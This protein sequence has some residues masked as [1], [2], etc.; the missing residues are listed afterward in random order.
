MKLQWRGQLYKDALWKSATATTITAFKK[1]MEDLKKINKD[2]YEWLNKIPAEHWSRSHFS[3]KLMVQ[4]YTL[5][6]IHLILYSIEQRWNIYSLLY[7]L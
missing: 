2:A 4:F 3:G 7:T 6:F 5:Y 1:H